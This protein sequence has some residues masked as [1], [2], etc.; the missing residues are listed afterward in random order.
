MAEEFVLT[1]SRPLD[2]GGDG[3]LKREFET[4]SDNS[5]LEAEVVSVEKV[6]KPFKDEHGQPI[7]RVEFEFKV[8]D[9]QH[10]GRR[11]WGD[12]PTTFTTHPDCKMTAW[13]TEILAVESL[14]ADFRFNTDSLNGSRARV[15]VGLREA[16]DGKPARNYVKDVIRSRDAAPLVPSRP[17]PAPAYAGAD[18]EP[19]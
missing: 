11:L 19:F 14:P 4:I 6:V 15:V 8:V 5:I 9:Q 16:K 7:V 17:A 1:E 13:V 12:T 10:K 18:E 3:S 2:D